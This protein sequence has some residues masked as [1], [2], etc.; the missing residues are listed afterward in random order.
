MPLRLVSRRKAAETEASTGDVRKRSLEPIGP[1]PPRQTKIRYQICFYDWG[2]SGKP[3][4][5]L[6]YDSP[7]AILKDYPEIK[8]N[9]E[10]YNNPWIEV[11]VLEGRSIAERFQL[12]RIYLERKMGGRKY[13]ANPLQKSLEDAI[14]EIRKQFGSDDSGARV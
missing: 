5:C 11:H 8:K 13:R 7:D 9:A 12:S 10:T 6:K 2:S 4:F 3:D 1:N 14:H